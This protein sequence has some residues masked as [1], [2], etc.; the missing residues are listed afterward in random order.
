[1]EDTAARR[2]AETLVADHK[3]GTQ[4]KAFAGL[5]SMGDAY[6]IQDRYVPLLRAVHV[7]RS[8]T[9]SG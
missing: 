9:R 6:D 3:A 2:T 8:A 4:F 7:S 5:S 1:M